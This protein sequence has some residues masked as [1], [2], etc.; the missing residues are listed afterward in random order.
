MRTQQPDGIHHIAIMSAD[1]KAQLTFFTQ[2]LGFPLVGLF[3]M[4]GVPGGRH[5]FLKMAEDS[6]FSVVELDGIAEIPSTLGI[7]HAGTGAGK[8][9]AGVTQHIAFR[10]PD[11]AGLL[12]MR[13]RIRSHGVPAL[14]P[15]GHGFCK[16]IYFA[17][18]EGLTLEVGY[19]V[20]EVDPK[21]WVDPRMLAECG[22]SGEEAEAM[23]NPAPCAAEAPV[24]Q[25]EY[26]PAVPQ[27]AYPA[28][29]LK[30]MLAVPDEAI[31][32]QGSYDAPPVAV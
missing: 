13:D 5:A 30:R 1:M 24:A 18:P 10:V 16:S 19:A 17:G 31:T 29:V 8:C 26:D 20:S 32:A 6:F 2:V 28:E 21:R 4:H 14:G 22:I 23:L 11:E 15:I 3:E 12:A 27:M 9:A 7:T 25:P